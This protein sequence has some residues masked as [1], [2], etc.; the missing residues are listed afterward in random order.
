MAL[1]AFPSRTLPTVRTRRNLRVR[2]LKRGML[3]HIYQVAQL[4]LS[5]QMDEL[6][7]IG[8]RW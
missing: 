8:P 3:E 4:E 6:I 5:V 1:L 7:S 2:I